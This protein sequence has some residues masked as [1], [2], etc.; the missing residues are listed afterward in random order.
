MSGT[1]A[2]SEVSAWLEANL[3]TWSLDDGYLTRTY[4]TRGWQLTR[5][6]G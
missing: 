6:C 5:I 1:Y 4:T 2:E 3:P